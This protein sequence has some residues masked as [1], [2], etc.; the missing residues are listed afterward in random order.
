V[1]TRQP[2]V[3]CFLTDILLTYLEERYS[4]RSAVD[5]PA[6]FRGIEGFVPPTDPQAFLR[7][8]NNWVPLA[9][10]RELLSQCERITGRKDAAYLAARAYFD[11]GRDD[12]LTLFEIS[13]R[14]AT[15]KP[16]SWS[17]TSSAAAWS[18]RTF[19]SGVK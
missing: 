4:A 8:G 10:L 6:L 3:T 15:P 1:E 16:A 17:S 18:R 9:V 13:S 5:F 7:Q 2:W 14:S 11:H 19:A 12:L